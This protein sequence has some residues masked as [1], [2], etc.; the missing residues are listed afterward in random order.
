MVS[1]IQVFNLD[2]GATVSVEVD[3]NPGEAERISTSRKRI[4]EETGKSFN[5]ALDGVQRAAAVVLEGFSE[6]LK[7]NELELSF[8]LKFSAEAGVLLASADAQATMSLTAK[9]K[10]P[11]G[12]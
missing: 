5:E 11:E 3:V 12:S 9:W 6:S 8:G 10:A 1:K 7:P 4:V 2:D